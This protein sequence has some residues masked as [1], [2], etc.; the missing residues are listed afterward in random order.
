MIKFF[1]KIRQNLLSEGKTGKYLK[2]AIGEIIL[3]VL[4]ILIALQLNN[5]N[6]ERK[7]ENLK[8]VYYEQL[9]KGF[10]KDKKYIE[11]SSN[12]L[13]SSLI[14]Y[15]TYME[16]FKQ[17]N[18]PTTKI[19][20]NIGSAYTNITT[21][22]FQS[23][24]ISTLQ[25]AGD[26]KLIPPFIRKKLISLQKYIEQ[27]ENVSKAN[28]AMALEALNYA[29]RF[30]G[31]TRLISEINNQPKLLEWIFEENRKI[32]MILALESSLYRKVLSENYS[33]NR[34]KRILLDMDEIT[35]LINDE[36]KK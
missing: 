36:L 11:E 26:I 3:V 28:D 9:L 22:Q 20:G 18:L 4:G 7:T 8:Q 14:K 32:Q 1:R 35:I 27:T 15:E 23:N 21:V 2:Y 5:L 12:S 24:T 31:S 34:F 29:N 19:I 17:E 30:Y 33:L 6:D 16:A 25:N 10:D 13:D